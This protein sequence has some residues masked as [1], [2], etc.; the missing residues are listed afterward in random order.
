MNMP[1]KDKSG[2][3][4]KRKCWNC[5]RQQPGDMMERRKVDV[6]CVQK[7]RWKGSKARGIGGGFKLFYHGVDGRINGVRV[8]VKEQ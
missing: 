6:H 4:V 2:S 5:D 8:T 3:E 1:K 7:T